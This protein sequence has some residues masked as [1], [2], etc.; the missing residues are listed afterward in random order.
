MGLMDETGRLEADGT[1]DSESM[2]PFRDR[3]VEVDG[4]TEFQLT[5][6]ETGEAIVLTQRDVRELQLA[7]AAIRSGIDALLN[8]AGLTSSDVSQLFLAG[9]F[10]SYLNSES[11]VRLGMIPDMPTERI[12]FIGNAASVGAKLA[13][14]STDMR[15]RADRLARSTEHLQIAET[16]DFQMRF[17]EAMLFGEQP[18]GEMTP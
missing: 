13:L 6:D 18:A 3:L 1:E 4:E 16:A 7:K 12:R 8:S 10:G 11:A 14:I 2:S 17:A 15:R 5:Q 9:G